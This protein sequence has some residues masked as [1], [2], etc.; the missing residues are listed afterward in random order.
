MK[1]FLQKGGKESTQ[2]LAGRDIHISNYS[3]PTRPEGASPEQLSRSH[4]KEKIKQVVFK[5]NSNF[6]SIETEEQFTELVTSAAVASEADLEVVIKVEPA[7]TSWGFS[8]EIDPVLAAKYAR[9]LSHKAENLGSALSKLFSQSVR[10][11]WGTTLSDVDSITVVARALLSIN[12]AVEGTKLDVWRTLDPKLSAPAWLSP[13]EEELVLIQLK[14]ESMDSL[15]LGAGWRA[16]DEL[17]RQV[18]LSKVMPGIL[19]AVVQAEMSNNKDLP[20]ETMILHTWHIG[21][22]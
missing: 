9:H 19:W 3:T 20:A 7:D 15:G 14:F 22:G 13:A 10:D 12:G 11:A 6:D 1:R 4:D 5:V 17:P 2:L 16:A 8:N 21:Q 18:L